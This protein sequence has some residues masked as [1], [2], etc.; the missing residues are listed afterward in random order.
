ME[1]WQRRLDDWPRL[2][3]GILREYYANLGQAVPA[4]PFNEAGIEYRRQFMAEQVSQYHQRLGSAFSYAEE[5]LSVLLND[6]RKGDDRSDPP[7]IARKGLRVT[8]EQALREIE[9]AVT[10]PRC[11]LVLLPGSPSRFPGVDRAL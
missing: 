1:I 5:G 2:Q 4:G 11:T 9:S 7:C 10:H 3:D 8:P 6:A